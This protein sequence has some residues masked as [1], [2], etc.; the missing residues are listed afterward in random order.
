MDSSSPVVITR[1]L[2]DE[3]LAHDPLPSCLSTTGLSSFL[4]VDADKLEARYV[5]HGAHGHDVGAIQGDRPVPRDVPVYYFEVTVLSAGESGKIGVGF[6]DSAFKLSRHVAFFL[7]ARVEEYQACPRLCDLR[8]LAQA[9]GLGAKQLW[10]PRGRRRGFPPIAVSRS[11]KRRCTASSVPC[12]RP[13]TP[14][15]RA[16]T[17]ARIIGLFDETLRELPPPVSLVSSFSKLVWDVFRQR[18]PLLTRT[19]AHPAPDAAA[20]GSDTTTPAAEK[21]TAPP[22]PRATSS[23]VA[24]TSSGPRCSSPRTAGTSGSPSGV[25]G[26]AWCPPWARTG[27]RPVLGHAAVRTWAPSQTRGGVLMLLNPPPHSDSRG[28]RIRINFGN[29][30]FAFNLEVGGPRAFVHASSPGRVVWVG[31]PDLGFSRLSS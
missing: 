4:D 7:C 22:S 16:A 28:E 14:P 9:A 11:L 31:A 1:A 27:A 5:G 8:L 19:L 30:P 15:E 12:S 3:H 29:A 21:S 2:E 10:L 13:G 20:Q 23:A 24:S 25:S 6:A 26:R 18:N 17:A